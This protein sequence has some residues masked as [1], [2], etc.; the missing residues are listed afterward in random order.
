M[1]EISEFI[2]VTNWEA[3]TSPE[4]VCPMGVLL[5]LV[6]Q[7]FK[8]SRAGDQQAVKPRG[9]IYGG[10]TD[11]SRNGCSLR[12]TRF[13]P[14]DLNLAERTCCSVFCMLHQKCHNHRQTTE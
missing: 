7:L 13:L 8:L 5:A 2:K 14:P 10:E 4:T 12:E 9:V 11:G 1:E 6:K 3:V